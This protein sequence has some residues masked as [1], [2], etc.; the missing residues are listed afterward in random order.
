MAVIA[1]AVAFVLIGRSSDGANGGGGSNGTTGGGPVKLTGV[2]AY[3]P[4]GTGGEHD[5]EAPLAADGDPATRWTTQRY[6][7]P[8]DL[9]KP[10]VGVVLSLPAAD[11]LTRVRVSTDTPGFQARIQVGDSQT[12]PFHDASITRTVNGVTTFPIRDGAKGRY[13]VVWITHL[14]PDSQVA[15]VNEV[16]AVA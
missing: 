6:E 15:H 1:G 5:A 3:D 2:T 13:L 7:T 11:Q 16:Q 14:P 10:G 12:G 9:A 4:F 8:G